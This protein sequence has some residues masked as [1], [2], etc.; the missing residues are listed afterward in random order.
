MDTMSTD[1]RDA[2]PTHELYQHAEHSEN[3]LHTH[4]VCKRTCAQQQ[5]STMAP[6]AP[7]AHTEGHERAT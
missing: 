4:L 3:E 6:S 5:C 1:A 2:T 7:S